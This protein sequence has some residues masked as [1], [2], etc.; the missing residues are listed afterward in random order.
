MDDQRPSELQGTD[1]EICTSGRGDQ[2]GIMWDTV[3]F[4]LAGE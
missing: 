2:N 1:L 3:S 4:G